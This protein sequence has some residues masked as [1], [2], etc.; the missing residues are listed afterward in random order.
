M[1]K[2]IKFFKLAQKVSDLS[3]HRKQTGAAIIKNNRIISIGVN[4][5][6]THPKQINHHTGEFGVSIHAE[7][8][9]LL[10]AKGN[11]EGSTIYIS[12]KSKDGSITNL[13]KPCANCLKL[14]ISFRIKYIVYSI[15]EGKFVKERLW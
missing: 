9:A 6:K 2:D 4:K 12:R 7:L 13:A 8:D 15:H 3:E 10:R 1:E 14:L 11:V 5:Y